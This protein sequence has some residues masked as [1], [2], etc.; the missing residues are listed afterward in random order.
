MKLTIQQFIEFILSLS[1]SDRLKIISGVFRELSE[2]EK[3]EAYEVITKQYLKN[4]RLSRIDA[5]MESIFTKHYDYTPYKVAMMGLN[6]FRINR[7][8]KPFM[9]AYARKVKAR[10]RMRRKLKE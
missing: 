1:K 6:Y 2:T 5:W 7:K 9:I 8:M 3:K 10:V 4:E